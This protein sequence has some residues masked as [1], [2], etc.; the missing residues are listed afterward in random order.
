[1]LA[2]QRES[3]MQ[4]TE[5][6]ATLDE[7][8]EHRRAFIERLKA[9]TPGDLKE[10]ARRFKEWTDAYS[11]YNASEKLAFLMKAIFDEEAQ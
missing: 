8:K 11:P 1:M 9:E 6:H 7:Y 2:N 4:L 10:R 3:P 5:H